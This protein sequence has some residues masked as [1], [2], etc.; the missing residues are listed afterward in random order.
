MFYAKTIRVI[1]LDVVKG[2]QV[3]CNASPGN[4]GSLAH[5]CVSRAYLGLGGRGLELALPWCFVWG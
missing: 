3:W 2:F 5:F 4:M 1:H